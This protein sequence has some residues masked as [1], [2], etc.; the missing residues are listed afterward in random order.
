MIHKIGLSHAPSD[1]QSSVY[2]VKA[3]RDCQQDLH[4]LDFIARSYYSTV[5]E[6][7]RRLISRKHTRITVGFH[8]GEEACAVPSTHTRLK[9]LGVMEL[10]SEGRNFLYGTV[11]L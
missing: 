9:H 11:E 2:G 3:V 10:A 7:G 5:A 1:R 8:Q 4:S 6:E